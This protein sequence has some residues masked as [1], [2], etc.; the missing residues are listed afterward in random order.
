MF[1]NIRDTLHKK[2][3]RLFQESQSPIALMAEKLSNF[4]CLMTMIYL[5]EFR[6]RIFSH[7]GFMIAY[8][9]TIVLGFHHFFK[10][11][12]FQTVMFSQIFSLLCSCS[13]F[14]ITSSPIIVFFLF[15]FFTRRELAVFCFGIIKKHIQR[16]FGKAFF[17]NFA[18][19]FH[20]FPSSKYLK[21]CKG[22]TL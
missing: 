19:G 17:T 10:L 21:I 8:I 6:S 22:E 4:S 5:K 14:R 13:D 2:F 11:P 1:L 12:Q 15:A 18:S 16:L 9:T 20:V 7:F 3:W